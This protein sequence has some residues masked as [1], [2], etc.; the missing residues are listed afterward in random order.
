MSA[1]EESPVAALREQVADLKDVI[2]EQSNWI[3]STGVWAMPSD[4]DASKCYDP[5]GRGVLLRLRLYNR[6]DWAEGSDCSGVHRE[7]T[8][9]GRD[10]DACHS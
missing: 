10:S 7:Q 3:D 8:S 9:L 2:E 6:L 1:T 4:P 5:T